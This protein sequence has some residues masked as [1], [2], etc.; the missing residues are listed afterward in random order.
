MFEIVNIVKFSM[1]I[2][3]LNIASVAAAAAAAVACPEEKLVARS[4]N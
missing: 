1:Q 3:I 4:L 2:S